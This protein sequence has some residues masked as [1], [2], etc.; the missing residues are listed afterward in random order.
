MKRIPTK[1]S[2]IFFSVFFV[3]RPQIFTY[4]FLI[5]ELLCLEK[6]VLSNNK[7]YLYVEVM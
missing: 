3:T 5:I 7:K 4:L 6:Y 1:L 2:S